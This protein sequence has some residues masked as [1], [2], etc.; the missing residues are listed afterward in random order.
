VN[1]DR[2]A[3]G[4]NYAARLAI[5]ARVEEV[6]ADL[7]PRLD[8]RSPAASWTRADI[9]GW[10][11][12]FADSEPPPPPEPR[13][14]GLPEGSMA[15]LFALLGEALPRDTVL[16]TD[17]GLHQMLAR[18]HHTVLAPRGLLLPSD[19]QSMGFGLPAAIGAKL[20]APERPVV[21]VIGDGGLALSGMEL[22]TLAREQV[23]L[24]VVVFNDG[25]LNLIR[26]QQIRD[27]G[28]THAVRLRNPDMEALAA[29]LGVD[30]ALASADLVGTVRG[31]LAAERPLLLE[32]RV[33]DSPDI[34]ALRATGTAK[35]LVRRAIGRRLLDRI[36]HLLGR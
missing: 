35:S 4:A 34:R 27:H 14:H 32:V 29:A 16:V 36:R 25:Y 17:S 19:F 9:A 12:R 11:A 10:R 20:A 1:S 13:V 2:G 8:E 3:L 23:P 24:V 6:L 26:L 18:R 28:H 15:G 21:A 22:L 33:G 30:Y 5:H 7:L 31:A